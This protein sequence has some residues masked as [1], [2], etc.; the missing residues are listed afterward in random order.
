MRWLIVEYS[1]E[2]LNKNLREAVLRELNT[3][4][5][6]IEKGEDANSSSGSD[7]CP[8][9]D[10]LSKVVLRQILPTEGKDKIASNQKVKEDLR[11]IFGFSKKKK[12]APEVKKEKPK[13]D[14]KVP[15]PPAKV[16]K[17]AVKKPPPLP[18]VPTPPPIKEEIKEKQGGTG[19]PAVTYVDAATQ[20]E[21]IDFQRARAKWVMNKFGKSQT[22]SRKTARKSCF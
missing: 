2:D 17:K 6:L 9:E 5:E 15:P 21:K 22:Q 11:S 14:K 20:T 19:E 4:K 3:N 7:D 12:P 1:E 13:E 16:E 18:A 10:N 8:S